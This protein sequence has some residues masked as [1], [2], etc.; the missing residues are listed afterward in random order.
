MVSRISKKVFFHPNNLIGYIGKNKEK[1]TF[2]NILMFW[3]KFCNCG[4]GVLSVN[5]P[6]SIFRNKSLNLLISFA[7]DFPYPIPPGLGWIILMRIFPR[8]KKA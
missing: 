2:V 4:H 5:F 8:L 7:S 1:K 6:H 3:T